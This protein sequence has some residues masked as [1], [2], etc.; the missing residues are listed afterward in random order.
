VID[1]WVTVADRD[2]FVATR[3]LAL[4]EGLL[5]GGSCGMALHGAI[6]VAKGIDDPEAMIVVILPDGGRSYLSKVFN[7]AWMTQYGFL[8][9]GGSQ[10]LGDVL[11][12]KHDGGEIP[13]LVTVRTHDKVGD[14]VALLHEH[15]VS[16]LPVVSARDASAVV[17]SIGERGL[18]KHAIGDPALLAAD[19]VDVMEAP[20]PAVSTTDAVEEAVELLTGERS[21]VLV[22]EDGRPVGIVTRAD[23]LGALAR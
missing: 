20:F 4:E 1:R 15:S 5:T 3:R 22:T 8:E 7:D 11:R 14:A 23:L 10:T 16:Q 19:V 13:P 17:G 21:A 9:R 2:S 12:R 18:L 6:E